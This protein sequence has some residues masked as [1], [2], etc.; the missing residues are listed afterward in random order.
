MEALK[1]VWAVFGMM[2]GKHLAAAMRTFLPHPEFLAEL[3]LE[4]S[5]R[6][7]LQEI[8]PATIDRLL[9]AE[10]A[11]LSP[12]G[13]AHTKPA[14]GAILQRVPVRTFAEQPREPGYFQV[15]LVGHDGGEAGGDHCYTLTST[16]PATGWSEPRAVRN[17]AGR[18]TT[19]ALE[20]IEAHSPI[21]VQGWH[22]DNGT[23]FLNAHM[24]RHCEAGGF[25]FTRSR[26]YK[27]NDNCYAE[28][29][30]DAVVR[31][32]VGYLRYEGEQ[33]CALL[34]ELYDTLRVLVNFFYP[35]RRLIEKQR[36]GSKVRKRYDTPKTPYQRVMACEVVDEQRKAALRAQMAEL[37]PLTL[38]RQLTECSRRLL[39]AVRRN[40][41]S[42]RGNCAAD[43]FLRGL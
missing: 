37:N 35:Q 24:E 3:E 28:Q 9:A 38:Q 30:N 18:W 13:I 22:S 34:N 27:K 1:R 15:D 8:S 7:K 42:T 11:A 10:R 23:E 19:E 25:E 5:V 16:D 2:C 31:R 43:G 26:F 21:P 17:K 39:N 12:T 33:H 6:E 36:I 4:E 41:C 14:H 32:W 20:W 40:S 29:K